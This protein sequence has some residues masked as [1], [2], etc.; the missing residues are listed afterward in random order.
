[1]LE[2]LSDSAEK[3]RT[4]AIREAAANVHRLFQDIQNKKRLEKMMDSDDKAIDGE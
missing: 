1:M 3:G 2:I 4:H